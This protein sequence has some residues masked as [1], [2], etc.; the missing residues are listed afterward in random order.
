MTT[1]MRPD[2]TIPPAAAPLHGQDIWHLDD[3]GAWAARKQA[4]GPLAAGALRR[5]A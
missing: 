1:A 5:Q 3:V 4:G 2:Y